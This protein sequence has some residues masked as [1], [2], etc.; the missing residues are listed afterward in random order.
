[1]IFEKPCPGGWILRKIAHE[2]SGQPGKGCYWD[3]HELIHSS[4][5]KSIPCP[6]WE[7]VE[8]DGKRL[9]WAI[10]GRLEAG[11]LTDEGLVDQKI[12]YDFNDMTFE[13]IAAPYGRKK[14]SAS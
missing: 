3:V 6:N 11:W 9:V 1:V 12:L 2:G 7:W 14:N 13:A 4:S 10:D 8:M 5:K